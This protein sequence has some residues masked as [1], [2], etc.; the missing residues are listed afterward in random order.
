MVNKIFVE[1]IRRA[2][3]MS[4]S[5]SSLGLHVKSQN[6]KRN[7]HWRCIAYVCIWIM[8]I[9]HEQKNIASY[10]DIK[11]AVSALT[12]L[13]LLILTDATHLANSNSKSNRLLGQSQSDGLNPLKR[14]RLARG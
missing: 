8:D 5:T 1:F 10:I 14:P 2:P 7:F 4:L 3:S 11:F 13:R 12:A 6:R 9:H